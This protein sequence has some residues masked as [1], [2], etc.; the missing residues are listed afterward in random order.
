MDAL[1]VVFI[2]LIVIGGALID[3]ALN[4]MISTASF[5]FVKVDALRWIFTQPR[6]RVHALSDHHY[7]RGVRPF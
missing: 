5:W 2:P 3:S 4:L 1:F 6:A 7:S